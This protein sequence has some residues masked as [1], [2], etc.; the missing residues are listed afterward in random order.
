[1]KD[2]LIKNNQNVTHKE[3]RDIPAL[4]SH[5]IMNFA[6]IGVN[7]FKEKEQKE[8]KA[9][10]LGSAVDTYLLDKDSFNDDYIVVP[11]LPT[12]ALLELYNYI[13]N[14][15]YPT[16][17]ALPE[18]LVEIANKLNLWKST[19]DAD[20]RAKLVEPI[21]DFIKF[22]PELKDKTAI[23]E[24]DLLFVK[25]S[26]AYLE[27]N[28]RD[29]LFSEDKFRINHY[30]VV[31]DIPLFGICKAEVDQLEVDFK[32]KTVTITDIKT[33]EEPSYKF[34]SAFYKY[35]YW[36]QGGFY[37][38]LIADLMCDHLELATF[39]LKNKY[40]YISKNQVNCPVV[41]DVSN[42]WYHNS[43]YGWKSINGWYNKGIY[44][45]VDEIMWHQKN[46]LF[47]YPREVYENGGR[48]MIRTPEEVNDIKM[49]NI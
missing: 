47:E 7:V 31:R 25:S 20:K 33:G 22:I 11:E 38:H 17:N 15:Y 16:F 19:K 40:I 43:M 3:Y 6:E 45:L 24:D 42:S 35:K 34:E 21:K 10:S 9:F 46:G 2:F 41:Y 26:S 29:E 18:D 39:S 44:E 49:K 8:S 30:Q 4:S 13:K 32:K 27:T 1:M 23:S 12:G 28:L 36:I 37:K 48:F 14:I 5:F